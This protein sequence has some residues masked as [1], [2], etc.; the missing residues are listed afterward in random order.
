MKIAL[1]ANRYVLVS[2][3]LFK[4]FLKTGTVGKHEQ[5]RLPGTSGLCH[6]RNEMPINLFQ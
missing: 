5:F 3:A 4:S 1:L 2:A 6:G